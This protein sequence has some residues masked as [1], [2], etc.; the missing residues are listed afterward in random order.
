MLKQLGFSVPLFNSYWYNKKELLKKARINREQTIQEF[1]NSNKQIT[2]NIDDLQV[3][4]LSQDNIKL[5]ILINQLPFIK[6]YFQNLLSYLPKEDAYKNLYDY[7]L[8]IDSVKNTYLS[9]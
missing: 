4:D 9:I 3:D 1:I 2:Q 7:V 6:R 5:D 8:S